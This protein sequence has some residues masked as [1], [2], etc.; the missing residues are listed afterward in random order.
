MLYSSMLL[1]NNISKHRSKEQQGE[2]PAA[3]E[4]M[5]NATI[6]MYSIT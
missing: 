4:C 2:I 1:K 6:G 5:N 3:I